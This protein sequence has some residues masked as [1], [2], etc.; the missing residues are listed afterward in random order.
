LWGRI[1][2]AGLYDVD[3]LKLHVNRGIGTINWHVRFF[4][5]PEIA[6]FDITNSGGAA[7]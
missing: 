2:Q 5:P 3:G 1:Y 7:A 6:C 4:C